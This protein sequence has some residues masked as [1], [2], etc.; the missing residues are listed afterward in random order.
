MARMSAGGVMTPTGFASVS[1]VHVGAGSAAFALRR[2]DE[3]PS[4]TA[5]VATMAIDVLMASKASGTT[6]TAHHDDG[7]GAA[8]TRASRS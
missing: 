5:P 7:V 4:D 1:G 2:S 8:A 6:D 3:V